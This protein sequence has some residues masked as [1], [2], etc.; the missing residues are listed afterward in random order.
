M[1]KS[2]FFGEI[3]QLGRAAS[4]E[5]DEVFAALRQM[6]IEGFQFSDREIAQAGEE[7]LLSAM[8]RQGMEADVIHTV[9]PLL[10]AD[11]KTFRTACQSAKDTLALLRR[12]SCKRLMVVALPVND[13][14]GETDRERA[15]QRMI[16][17]LSEIA[18]EANGQGID[19]YIENFSKALLPYTSVSDIEQ[20]LDALPAVKY[21]FD[22][23]NFVCVCEDPFAAYARLRDRVS[24][25]HLKSFSHTDQK[26]GFLC[27]DGRYVEGFPFDR[28]GFDMPA[29][30]RI[31][32]TDSGRVLP[33]IEHNAAVTLDDIRRSAALVDQLLS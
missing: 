25:L 33:V 11:D 14:A 32:S 29:F 28:G 26:K 23:G 21:T 1:R 7:R 4:G 15:M 17:G 20:I 16:E 27:A 10:S 13:V 5:F 9:V 30:L 2:I 22:V 18:R 12:F 19:V 6:R 3:R 24:L 31:A 8:Q